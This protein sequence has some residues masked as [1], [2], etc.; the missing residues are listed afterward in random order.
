MKARLPILVC[1]GFAFSLLFSCSRSPFTLIEVH[2]EVSTVRLYDRAQQLITQY[3][4]LGVFLQTE[5]EQPSLQLEVTSPDG[6]NTWLFKAEKKV[7]DGIPYY[8]SANLSLGPLV[9]IAE[10][11]WSLR[12]LKDDGRTLS[13][14][15]MVEKGTA[16]PRPL[17]EVDRE[18]W[19][20]A[21]GDGIG[22]YGLQL[23]DEKGRLLF[24][25]TT[26]DRQV[27]LQQLYKKWENVH[28]LGLAW[29]DERAKES[30]IVW[31]LL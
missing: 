5:E 13:D 26:G 18:S 8:G 20:L 2:S 23:L 19:T 15:F 16:S 1:V 10:G 27:N 14:S 4:S 3:E 11:Q 25:K 7:V 24:S 9:P 30:Q 31:Y 12:V 28:T 29:Y 21:V 22:E 6:L 17:P